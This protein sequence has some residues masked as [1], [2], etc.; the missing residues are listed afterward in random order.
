M[1]RNYLK[2]FDFKYKK[3]ILLIYFIKI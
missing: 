3:Y 2:S 1:F